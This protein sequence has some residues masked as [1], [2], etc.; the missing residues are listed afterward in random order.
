MAHTVNDTMDYTYSMKYYYDNVE[1]FEKFN[2]KNGPR[3]WYTFTKVSGLG[4]EV[5]SGRAAFNNLSLYRPS[6]M[7]M[8]DLMILKIL[9]SFLKTILI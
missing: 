6:L 5:I 1:D 8:I 9:T 7:L 3:S 4:P 2:F